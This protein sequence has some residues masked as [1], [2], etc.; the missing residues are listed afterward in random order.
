LHYL[1]P[2]LTTNKSTWIHSFTARAGAADE[3]HAIDDL[4][5]RYNTYEYSNN[6]TTGL[7]GTWQSSNT[8]SGLAAGTYP[9][10]VRSPSNPSCFS[11][12][13]T[14]VVGTSPSPSS[15]LTVAASGFNTTICAGSSTDLTT[16][17]SIPGATFLWETASSV[18]GPYTPATGT[19]NTGTYS[20]GS[21]LANTYYRCTF[22]C[23]SSSPVTSTPVLVD[24]E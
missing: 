16:D 5:I 21:L 4:N 20:T 9:M 13:G 2:I 14:A 12:T 10:W 15:A 7:D 17:V 8:F 23:P 24:C 19:N 18:G 11:N 3:L 6:S 22:T 1:L